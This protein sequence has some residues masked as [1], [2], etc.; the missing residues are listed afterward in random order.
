MFNLKENLSS[1]M[2]GINQSLIG[3]PFDTTKVWMQNNQQIFGRPL[4]QYYRGYRPE[5]TN[6]IITNNIVFPMHA[7]SLSYTNNSF[8]SGGFAGL[9][10][11]PIVYMFRFNKIFE[12]VDKP[13]SIHKFINYKGR[14]YI[15]T[16]L[17]ESIGYSMYFGSYSYLKDQNIPTFIA[18]G[19]AGLCNWGVSFP[20]DTIMT[21]QIAQNINVLKA[22]QLGPLYKG[23]GVCLVRSMCVNSF[24]FLVYENIKS[25]F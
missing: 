9:C 4:R 11:S 17:R 18:G 13:F 3:I 20:F 21:R 19:I 12:Q 10:A 14:G 5:F 24:N 7:Y 15:S 2:V 6:A 8:I 23:Y 1:I 16:M 22:I 25:L